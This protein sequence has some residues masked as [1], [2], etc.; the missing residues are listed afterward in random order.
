MESY[1]GEIKFVPY[2]FE[3]TNWAFCDGRLLPIA[4][5]TA[6]F[7]FLGTDFGGNGVDTFGLPDLRGRCPV[8]V[9]QGE[10]L[11]QV[12]LAESSGYEQ[13]QLRSQQIPSVSAQVAIPVNTATPANDQGFSQVPSETCLL[14]P[15]TEREV[16][17][18]V[19]LYGPPQGPAYAGTLLP[20]SITTEAGDRLLDLDNPFL[21]L[22]C[23][24]CMKG[25]PPPRD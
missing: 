22:N 23:I 14:S 16:G 21:G 18:T 13:A 15:T 10:G 6:L 11:S 5:H 1:V 7:T 19:L 12:T 3:P 24:I 4:Q 2:D 25:N 9:G 17:A 20:F 8:G